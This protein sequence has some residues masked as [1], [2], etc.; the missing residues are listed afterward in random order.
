MVEVDGSQ[1][2]EPDHLERDAKRDAY[3][4]EMG[5]KVLRFDSRQVLLQIDGVIEAIAES[6]S[7][8]LE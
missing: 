3:L 8:R 5:L 4:G 7:E 1:H 6:V 2:L